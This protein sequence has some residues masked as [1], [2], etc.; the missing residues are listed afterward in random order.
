MKNIKSYL[1]MFILGGICFSGIGAFA[2][3]IVTADKIEYATN[4]SVKDKVDD[5]Y[6]KVKPI[7]TGSVEVTPSASTQTLQTN[8]K[9]LNSNITINPIPSSYKNISDTTITSASDIAKGKYAYNSSGTRLLGTATIV[10]IFTMKLRTESYS[11][12]DAGITNYNIPTSSIAN[13]Y[14]YFKIT[15]IQS[16]NVKSYEL[17]GNSN[18]GNVALSLNTQY[19]LSNITNFWVVVYS[20]KTGQMGYVVPTVEFYN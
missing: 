4:V 20:N 15:N 12:T 5:L 13:N 11:S 16:S 10:N 19:Q 18:S 2:E 17:M 14:K 9:I 1:L 6:T 8:N 7:Y 3:Y